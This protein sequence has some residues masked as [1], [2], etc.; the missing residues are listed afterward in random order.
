MEHSFNLV[1]NEKLEETRDISSY[2][3]HQYSSEDVQPAVGAIH[4]VPPHQIDNE[5]IHKGYRINFPLI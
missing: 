4:E 1:L 5:F 3:V 2:K